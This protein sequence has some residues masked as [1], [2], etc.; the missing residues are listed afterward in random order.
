MYAELHL[1]QDFHPLEE[2]TL[3]QVLM[4]Q[5]LQHLHMYEN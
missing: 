3:M 4:K 2:D 1:M 5:A